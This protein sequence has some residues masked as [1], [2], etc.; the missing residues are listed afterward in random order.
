[1]IYSMKLKDFQ[2]RTQF[3]CYFT[4]ILL[5]SIGFKARI[6]LIGFLYESH[7]IFYLNYLYMVCSDHVR[8]KIKVYFEKM[9]IMLISPK[10]KSFKFSIN[11]GNMPE[12][13]SRLINIFW[14][15]MRKMLILDFLEENCI[16]T[17]LAGWALERLGWI[18]H[19]YAYPL[20]SNM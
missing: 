18:G 16:Y 8:S 12:H 13:C 5:F 10:K 14:L 1:M 20:V 19:R 17:A 4:F 6:F 2:W 9:I 3:L 11:K 7:L 15:H